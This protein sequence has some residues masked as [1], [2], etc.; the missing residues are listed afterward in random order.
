MYIFNN[1]CSRTFILFFN[2]EE[3]LK[4]KSGSKGRNTQV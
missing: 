1:S 2:A 3:G 4:Y